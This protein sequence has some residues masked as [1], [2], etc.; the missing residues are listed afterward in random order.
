M[1]VGTFGQAEPGIHYDNE[2]AETVVDGMT[3]RRNPHSDGGYGLN[4]HLYLPFSAERNGM[5]S[6]ERWIYIDSHGKKLD[7][8]FGLVM[9]TIKD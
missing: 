7:F 1:E 6:T 5:Q 8:I 4:G 2:F 9:K 3:N